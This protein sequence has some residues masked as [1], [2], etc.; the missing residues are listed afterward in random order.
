M[1]IG[2]F[3]ES[4]FDGKIQRDFNNM[5]TE[6]AWYAALDVIHHWIGNLSNLQDLFRKNLLHIPGH[7]WWED[8]LENLYNSGWIY[9]FN[10][11]PQNERH[12][13]YWMERVYT[14]LYE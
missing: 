10:A 13:A 5:R 11:I 8:S 6:Y 4:N 12:V 1:N 9:H 3:S 7:S 2:F 14:E